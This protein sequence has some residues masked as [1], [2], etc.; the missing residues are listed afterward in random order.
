MYHRAALQALSA[1]FFLAASVGA[2]PPTDTFETRMTRIG[3]LPERPYADVALEEVPD[4]PEV[5][6]LST[7]LHESL[8]QVRRLPD[9]ESLLTLTQWLPHRTI[10]RSNE[11][12][13]TFPKERLNAARN[14]DPHSTGLE[15]VHQGMNRES[16]QRKSGV[17]ESLHIDDF[18]SVDTRWGL[19][20]HHEVVVGQRYVEGFRIGGV[21]KPMLTSLERLERVV[22]GMNYDNFSAGPV[23]TQEAFLLTAIRAVHADD[24]AG[25]NLTSSTITITN[26]TPDITR[27]T[28]IFRYVT[29]AWG[30][31]HFEYD[32]DARVGGN[33][34]RIYR[35]WIGETP[36]GPMP[37]TE[38][39]RE[40]TYTELSHGDK[41][42]WLLS[43]F[44]KEQ[45]GAM[46]KDDTGYPLPKGRGL[47]KRFENVRLMEAPLPE[48]VFDPQ[49]ARPNNLPDVRVSF[50]GEIIE[51][52]T[53]A[54]ALMQA[55]GS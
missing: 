34:V 33:L 16:L 2:L 36:A 4:S 48:G 5:L 10:L 25:F 46:K 29:G 11:D 17:F 22:P 49:W 51:D 8:E 13:P 50:Q 18:N 19:V 35:G 14:R 21:E 38:E 39:L 27:Y 3:A 7:R 24:S 37:R 20:T 55:Y 40:A 31:N 12:S 30:Y 15:R 1:A 32:F 45:R 43:S 52:P 54:Q 44:S 9:S 53:T 23:I 26:P 42:V 47:T 28:Q 41:K 6:E